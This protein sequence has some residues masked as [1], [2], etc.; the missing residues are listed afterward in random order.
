ML[1][2]II[3]SKNE[4]LLNAVKNSIASTISVPYEI[5]AI[6]NPN[7]KFGICEAYNKGAA[8]AKYDYLCFSHEDIIFHTK[9]WGQK[10]VAHLLNP[11]VGLIGVVGCIIK[12]KAPSG[13]WLNSHY[14]N[15]IHMIQG[16]TNGENYI[17]YDNPL[18]ENISEVKVIDGLWMCCRKEVWK[19]YKFDEISFKEFHAYDIDFSLQIGLKYKLYIVYDIELEHLSN[20]GYSISWIKNM[21]QVNQKWKNLLP[22]YTSSFSKEKLKIVEYNSYNYFIRAIIYKR[23]FNLK[24]IYYFLKVFSLSPFNVNNLNLVKYFINSL[25]NKNEYK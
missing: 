13:V 11:E 1:S 18:V 16:N 7:G 15:R 2:I 19:Q 8:Q 6:N 23:F 4:I 21:I 14:V 24:T 17:K 10:V 20:G 9:N 22:V 25:S 5:I 3:C 12:P